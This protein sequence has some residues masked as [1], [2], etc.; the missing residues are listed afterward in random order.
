MTREMQ[1]QLLSELLGY[2][3]A[4]MVLAQLAYKLATGPAVDDPA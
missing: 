3:V 4:T 2:Q 1:A